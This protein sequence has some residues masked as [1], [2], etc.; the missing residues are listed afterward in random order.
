MLPRPE[1]TSVLGWPRSLP[2]LSA[3]AEAAEWKMARTVAAVAAWVVVE[4][5]AQAA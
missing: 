2:K 1:V 5:E 3:A 4:A